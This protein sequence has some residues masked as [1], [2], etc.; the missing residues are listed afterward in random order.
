MIYYKRLCCIMLSFWMIFALSEDIIPFAF[1]AD[2]TETLGSWCV[3]EP[4]NVDS[5]AYPNIE[6]TG[7]SYSNEAVHTLSYQVKALPLADDA[8]VTGSVGMYGEAVASF[9][10]YFPGQGFE[11]AYYNDGTS[12]K[13]KF[14]AKTDNL[15]AVDTWYTVETEWCEKI[16]SR[17]MKYIIKDE[18][19]T[20]ILADSGKID[21]LW[22]DNW[23]TRDV[24][25]NESFLSTVIFPWNQTN[26]TIQ[27][28]N[29]VITETKTEKDDSTEPEAPEVPEGTKVIGSNCIG[30]PINVVDGSYP[31]ISFGDIKY[32][33]TMVHTISYK[34]KATQASSG[35]VSVY[36]EAVASF[37]LYIP[38]QGFEGAYYKDKDGSVK[39]KFSAKGENFE[40]IN[41]WYTVET[42]WYEGF[43]NRYMKYTIKDDMGNILAQS[44]KIPGIWRDNWD[45]WD[46]E[47]AGSIL[48]TAVYVYNLSGADVQVKD[49]IVTEAPAERPPDYDPTVL[50][51]TIDFSGCAS[52]S[53]VS[54]LGVSLNSNDN[55]SIG[56]AQEN[57]PMGPSLRINRADYGAE[58]TAVPGG[59]YEGIYKISYW[60]YTEDIGTEFVV[61]APMV[62]GGF[63]EGCLMLLQ[64]SDNLATVNPNFG[65]G[66]K[67]LIIA[68]I[69]E[70]TWYCFEHVI[71]VNTRMVTTTAYKADGSQTGNVVRRKFTNVNSEFTDNA[72]NHFSGVRFRNWKN[73]GT[74]ID[75]IS[76][77]REFTDPKL[78]EEDISFIKADGTEIG[79][80]KEVSPAVNSIALDFGTSITDKSAKNG[81]H[82]T[83]TDGTEVLFQGKKDKTKYLISL[84]H[85]LE[86]NQTYTLTIEDV[87]NEIGTKISENLSST[88]TT[89]D[90]GISAKISSICENDTVLEN[91]MPIAG[92][93]LKVNI[94]Y[95]NSL[96]T[97][98][99]IDCVVSY[100]DENN[101]A[102]ETAVHKITAPA[103][104]SNSLEISSKAVP[105][106]C[107]SVK[108][109]LLR[110]L[111]SMVS[112]DGYIADLTVKGGIECDKKCDF[113]KEQFEISGKLADGRD[114]DGIVTIQALRSGE[115]FNGLNG[116]TEAE[117]E[118]A[119][120]YIG[121]QK[122]DPTTGRFSFV[123]GYNE[124]DIPAQTAKALS[125]EVRIVGNHGEY[126]QNI[127]VNLASKAAYA[128]TI[129]KI[130]TLAANS[131]KTDEEFAAE[132]KLEFDNLGLNSAPLEENEL[133]SD[134]L[135]AYRKH[136]AS[137]AA[138]AE[139]MIDN[140][141]IFTDF[142]IMEAAKK[143]TS[144][145]LEKYKDNIYQTED[146]LIKAYDD[147]V[148]NA[149]IQKYFEKK[150]TETLKSSRT[151]T[152]N[153]FTKAWKI[154]VILTNARYGSGYGAFKSALLAYGSEIGI[155]ATKSDGVYQK[156]FRKDYT[157]DSL[158]A[159]F[160]AVSDD[161]PQ[162]GGGNG[163]GGG[164]GSSSGGGFSSNKVSGKYTVPIG[165]TQNAAPIRKSFSD[166]DSVEWASEAILAL[167]DK[168]IVDGVEENVF[169][170]NAAVTREEFVKILI[171]AMG[172]GDSNYTNY[173]SDVKDDDWFCSCVNIAYENG[174][175]NGIGS[176]CFGVGSKLTRQDMVVLL[177]NSLSL[178][179]VDLPNT[180]EL[181]FDDKDDIADYARTAVSN[182]TAIG[183][184]N[185]IS[186][187]EFS[188][189]GE[190]TRAQAATIIYRSLDM[191]Q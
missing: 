77:K 152:L 137:N 84:E 131:V 53:D 15:K 179:G 157:A 114:M 159:A 12:A 163:S 182:M 132:L 103:S 133:N 118:N 134:T 123:I 10:R 191:L 36:G 99:N 175:C 54:R 65:D 87:E 121:Q 102:I 106:N 64:L 177:N 127:T 180:G 140:V 138:S 174:I 9:G 83:K 60:I 172:L 171:G 136:L 23:D 13:A 141:N 71:D 89:G 6:L 92:G 42:E 146:G 100:Y 79:Y 167:A 188:P 135:K 153:E 94:E 8:A 187:T 142:M 49:V 37:G 124:E 113:S 156:L 151:A 26:T 75:N 45:A 33:G 125:H 176:G 40:Q 160:D 120:L 29:V 143:N 51:D 2:K 173:F 186:D 95:I 119:I 52:L 154:A 22:R 96:L 25:D 166:I 30:N 50:V 74:L 55:C 78:T 1:A 91:T 165:S 168:G 32:D 47:Y 128:E 59:A 14:S 41:T 4:L 130:N 17:Y 38:G 184:V 115:S 46:T 185:G 20:N 158:K 104:T 27:I 3:D 81:I 145:D 101:R 108:A 43:P 116:K 18:T 189:M 148:K 57:D 181:I 147:V 66:Q 58:I 24:P 107:A 11:G 85:L 162:G 39:P 90:G 31:E 28:K 98:Q 5:G 73:V 164:G 170:P 117:K 48:S 109:M 86:P 21:G 69:R 19:G 34:I 183:A 76:I 7:V 35:T 129:G 126:V 122:A 139:E 88:F 44:D 111:E 190:A 112:Y 67:G 169:K 149:E 150:F 56:M 61:D 110:D 97:E 105:E 144:I 62:M 82:L 16:G 161:K 178:K 70:K 80:T 93:Q 68:P 155:T 63:E 72:I